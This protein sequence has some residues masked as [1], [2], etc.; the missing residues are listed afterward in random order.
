MATPSRQLSKRGCSGPVLQ[1]RNRYCAFGDG[2]LGDARLQFSAHAR[3]SFPLL[4][5]PGILF[6]K[7]GQGVCFS[8]L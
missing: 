6:T 1:F 3:R 4:L 5:V 7:H 2:A 8:C